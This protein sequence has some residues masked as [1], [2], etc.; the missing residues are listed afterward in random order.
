M[1]QLSKE[2]LYR[3][4]V[5]DDILYVRLSLA[6]SPDAQH[7]QTGGDVPSDGVEIDIGRIEQ[8]ARFRHRGEGKRA[9]AA[10]LFAG[11]VMS[12]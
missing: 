12:R 4:H 2:D 11:C 3:N 6:S 1:D 7:V 5:G 9:V 10:S 8:P